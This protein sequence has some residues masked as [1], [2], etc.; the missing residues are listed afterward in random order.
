MPVMQSMVDMRM[1]WIGKY[2]KRMDL[3]S[4][5]DSSSASS[6]DDAVL[7]SQWIAFKAIT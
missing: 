1:A 4:D 3:T 5:E 7:V 6:S 2:N